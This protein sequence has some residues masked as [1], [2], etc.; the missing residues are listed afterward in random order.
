MT[1]A[2]LKDERAPACMS[3]GYFLVGLRASQCPECGRGFDPNDPATMADVPLRP[4]PW[5]AQYGGWLR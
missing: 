4:T 5:H 2:T 1:D 3:C